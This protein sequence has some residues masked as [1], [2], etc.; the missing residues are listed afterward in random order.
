MTSQNLWYVSGGVIFPFFVNK[1]TEDVGF[2]GAV[3]Y[4]A[5]LIGI[6][7]AISCCLITS[8]LPPKPWDSKRKWIDFTLLKDRSF[9]LYTVGAY[10]VMWVFVMKYF[11]T[12]NLFIGGDSGHRSTTSL[13]WHKRLHPFRHR[14]RF[15]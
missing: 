2:Y 4:T 3:R 14:C 7:L 8:R 12:I 6:L 15:T 9:A 10:L 13:R 1:V 5:L 11:S